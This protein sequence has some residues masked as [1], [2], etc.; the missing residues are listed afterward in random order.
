LK[1][2]NKNVDKKWSDWVWWLDRSIY[3]AEQVIMEDSS[4][5]FEE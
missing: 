1:E 4:K 3:L 5:N 2:Q